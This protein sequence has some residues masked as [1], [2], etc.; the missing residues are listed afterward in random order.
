MSSPA[1]DRKLT[2]KQRV[3]FE[4]YLANGFNA[5]EAAR[6]AKYKDPNRA[7]WENTVKHRDLIDKELEHFAMGKAEVLARITAQARG[8]I[9]D[10]LS[11]ER[12]S[13]REPLRVTREAAIR[14]TSMK[15]H[16]RRWTLEHTPLSHDEL[17]VLKAEIVKLSGELERFE[18]GE[19][20]DLVYLH[21]E[22]EQRERTEIYID[23]ERAK[24]SNISHLIKRYS[25]NKDGTLK[26]ELYDAQK[27]LDMLA[28]AHGVYSEPVEGNEG[29]FDE[30][31]DALQQ[32]KVKNG[33]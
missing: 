12:V 10:F 6:F 31:L 7:G 32:V 29:E 23:I 28:K 21:G 15:L 11:I 13:Y 2:G 8:D 20:D 9:G 14:R 16:D 18:K 33:V 4:R 26:L 22:G 25:V 5:T 3:W 1:S 19:H 27:A 24:K 17:D 30:W